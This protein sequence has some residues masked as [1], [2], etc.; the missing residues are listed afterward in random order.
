MPSFTI[1]IE[2]RL[3]SFQESLQKI[4]RDTQG[5]A[6]KISRQFGGLE[7][8][9]T[10]LSGVLAGAFS[11]TAAINFGR[12]ISQSVIEAERSAAQLNAT[13][14]ATGYAAG[15]SREQLEGLINDLSAGT[16]F[17]DDPIRE[18]IATLLRFRGVAREVFDDAVSE[19][20]RRRGSEG[21]PLPETM[22]A[23]V[24]RRLVELA[25]HGE[26]DTE[27]LRR[28]AIDGICG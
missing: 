27:R 6:D 13:L 3:A 26:S 7:S 1:D 23:E 5:I 24:A 9:F 16:V 8:V 4:G 20:E 12:A 18:G 10:R 21:A 19:L 2:A 22:R 11:V 25:R 14:R 17:D 15:R 28:A